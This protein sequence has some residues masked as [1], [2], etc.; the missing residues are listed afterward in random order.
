MPGPVLGSGVTTVN[1]TDNTPYI[2]EADILVGGQ[3][4]K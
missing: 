2:P 1:Q 4:E 3:Q